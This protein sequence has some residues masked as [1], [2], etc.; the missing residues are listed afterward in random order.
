MAPPSSAR[1]TPE[2]VWD[3][4]RPPRIEANALSLQVEHGGEVLAKTSAG[5]RILETSHPPTY[6]LPPQS[7]DW[8]RL[9]PSRTRTL[10]E[11][12]GQARYWSL[13]TPEG[14]IPDVCWA[15]PEPR[16]PRIRDHV[17]FYAGKV[18]AC[19]VDGEQVQAQEGSFYGGWINSWIKGPFKGGPGTRGW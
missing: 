4:P 13:R 18:D 9:V 12:K 19:F 1:P 15:Y 10:C 5:Y 8:N 2:S 16:D 17:S 14:L 7:V 3:Y 6:Y 11:W